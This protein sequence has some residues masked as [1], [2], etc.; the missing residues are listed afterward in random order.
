MDKEYH[1]SDRIIGVYFKDRQQL[2]RYFKRNIKHYHK[3][4]DVGKTELMQRKDIPRYWK[5]STI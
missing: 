3:S 4:Y 1:V 5:L 2:K